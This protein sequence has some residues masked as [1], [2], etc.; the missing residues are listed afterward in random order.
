MS[1][2]EERISNTNGL[3]QPSEI[4]NLERMGCCFPTRLS[5]M[6]VL[7]RKLI[8][9]KSKVNTHIWEMDKNGYGYAVHSISLDKKIFSL[10]SFSNYLE[11]SMRTDRVIASAWDTSFAL[12][13][14]IPNNL[15]IKR[16][17][18]VFL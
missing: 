12:F 11:N 13:D 16:N 9:N 1:I 8:N 4:M 7:I 2:N 6:R 3:R 14:G 18:N 5:F 15:D 10:I 17:F